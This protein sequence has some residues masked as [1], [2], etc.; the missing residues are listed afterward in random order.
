MTDRRKR[1]NA[2]IHGQYVQN[3]IN[4]RKHGM[5]STNDPKIDRLAGR[6]GMQKSSCV[7]RDEQE[8]RNE[9]NPTL[10]DIFFASTLGGLRLS[11]GKRLV[12]LDVGVTHRHE[13]EGP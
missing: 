4:Q 8:R 6:A 13:L 3:T 7:Y 10:Y 9:K 11:P 1:R 5:C 12:H 2:Y